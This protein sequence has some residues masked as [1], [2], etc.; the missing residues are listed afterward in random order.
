[1]KYANN[2]WYQLHVQDKFK[3]LKQFTRIR[4]LEVISEVIPPYEAEAF[5]EQWLR[6]GFIQLKDITSPP[7]QLSFF[8]GPDAILAE[9]LQSPEAQVYTVT[10]R[11]R[12]IREEDDVTHKP[13]VEAI[14][15]RA[16]NARNKEVSAS[17]RDGQS[18]FRKQLVLLHKR[19]Q[20]CGSEVKEVLEAAHIEPFA[21][22]GSFSVSNGLILRSDYH[23]LFDRLL[24]SVAPDFSIHVA[25]SL[26]NTEY[27]KHEKMRIPEGADTNYIR[28][29]EIQLGAQ[30]Q[31]FQRRNE[32]PS[33]LFD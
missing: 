32:L 10:P 26:Q 14:L 7:D 5:F 29:M 22:G 27:A 18:L 9:H 33:A 19:C 21:N 28:R 13:P 8:D 15:I 3:A 2:Y 25:P 11:R 16:E 31:A 1:M 12:R 20:I 30:F 23:A 24:L 6:A 4:A 17:K